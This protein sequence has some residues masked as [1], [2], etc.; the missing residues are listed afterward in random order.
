MGQ[1]GSQ[2][3]APPSLLPE[4]SRIIV[5]EE[6]LRGFHMAAEITSMGVSPYLTWPRTDSPE[7][8]L[9]MCP[10]NLPGLNWHVPHLRLELW[11]K[12]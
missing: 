8:E 9:D 11:C 7:D 1:C 2:R 5:L 12:R 10:V 3:R 6:L 4:Q